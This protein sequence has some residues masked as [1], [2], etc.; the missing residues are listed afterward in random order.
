MEMLQ[1]ESYSRGLLGLLASLLYSREARERD[2]KGF[3]VYQGQQVI[4]DT[5]RHVMMLPRRGVLAWRSEDWDEP[6]LRKAVCLCVPACPKEVPPA[7]RPPVHV[8]LV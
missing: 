7:V 8:Y 1:H 5:V 3:L 2:I 4:V 6:L